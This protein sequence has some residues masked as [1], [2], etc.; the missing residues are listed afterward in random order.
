MT[1]SSVR[2]AGKQNAAKPKPAETRKRKREAAQ[3]QQTKSRAK[4][5]QSAPVKPADADELALES[6]LFGADLA[7]KTGVLPFEHSSKPSDQHSK[8]KKDKIEKPAFTI[9]T[10]G[11]QADNADEQDEDED[12]ELD[13]TANQQVWHDPDDEARMID[14]SANGRMA[15]LKQHENEQTISATEFQQRLRSLYKNLNHAASWALQTKKQSSTSK[16]DELMATDVNVLR[17]SEELPSGHLDI[18]AMRDANFVEPAQV[19]LLF[20][21]QSFYL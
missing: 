2:E 12:V 15:K 11:S 19:S 7:N 10:Q 14:L 18:K 13:S 21:K 1:G 6:L 20:I 3:S 4:L 8:T 16:F 5:P 17:E 9:D